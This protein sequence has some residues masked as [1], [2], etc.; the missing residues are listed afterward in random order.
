MN[1]STYSRCVGGVFGAPPAME[2]LAAFLLESTLLGGWLFLFG[3]DSIP[4]R[5]QL[6]ETCR[7]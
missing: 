5:V 6:E 4:K 7:A 2:G 1:W 3:C